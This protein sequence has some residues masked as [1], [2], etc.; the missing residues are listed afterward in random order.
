MCVC[1]EKKKD[2]TQQSPRKTKK[3]ENSNNSHLVR[4]PKNSDSNNDS[5]TSLRQS[6]LD[7][8]YQKNYSSAQQV[9]PSNEDLAPY[10]TYHLNNAT[11]L[12]TF[13]QRTTGMNEQ[14]VTDNEE[15]TLERV[16]MQVLQQLSRPK[17]YT[18]GYA[19]VL[20]ESPS[21]AKR[22]LRQV[23]IPTA[24]SIPGSPIRHPGS[25]LGSQ[26]SVVGM[27]YHVEN[28]IATYG[29]KVLPTGSRPGTPV[30]YSNCSSPAI[31]PKPLL[32]NNDIRDQQLTNSCE[33]MRPLEINSLP[34]PPRASADSNRNYE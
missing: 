22:K 28:S 29:I 34:L 21:T 23:A 20:A 24:P 13:Q 32:I 31:R 4:R 5:F 2:I 8:K 25:Q 16:K 7:S 27:P 6:N 1:V 26:S 18:P 11:E 9:R 15:D 17:S 19:N 10:A 14:A 30:S 12:Q 33:M 3:S